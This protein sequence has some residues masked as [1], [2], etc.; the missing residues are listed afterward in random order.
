M[1]LR[2]SQIGLEVWVNNPG[3]LRVTQLGLEVW[4]H[5]ASK[6]RVTQVG[7]EVWRTTATT[8]FSVAGQADGYAICYA[9]TNQAQPTVGHADGYATVRDYKGKEG[10]FMVGMGI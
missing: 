1:S 10:P 5:N 4:L 2:V 7:L 8:P 3:H 6:T 9:L